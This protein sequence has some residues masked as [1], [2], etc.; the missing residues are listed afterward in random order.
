LNDDEF[1]D[2]GE[3]YEWFGCNRPDIEGKEGGVGFLVK[4]GLS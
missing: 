4:K 1:V 3:G 2:G